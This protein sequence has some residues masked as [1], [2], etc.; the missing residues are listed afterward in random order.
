LIPEIHFKTFNL[1]C[2]LLIYDGNNP[3][4]GKLNPK[5]QILSKKIFPKKSNSF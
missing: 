1:K 5:S 3:G 2:N 4:D